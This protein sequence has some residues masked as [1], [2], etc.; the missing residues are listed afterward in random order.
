MQ[1]ANSLTIVG[2]LLWAWLMMAQCNFAQQM[3]FPG[4][5]WETATP[6]SQMVDSNM[7]Q[8]AVDF[9][10]SKT[11]AGVGVSELVIIRNGRM[12]WEGPE[13]DNAHIVYSMTKS[14][15]STTLGLLVDDGLVTVD[16]LAKE[17]VPSMATDYPDVALSHLATHT[18][19]YRAE[20]EAYPYSFNYV[21]ADPFTPGPPLFETGSRFS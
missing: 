19:G 6:E 20:E 3:V 11:S 2:V 13:S 8:A 5:E 18:S 7:L 21:P 15:A 4:T 16:T 1:R 10:D 17:Y 9:L 12:I 14:F